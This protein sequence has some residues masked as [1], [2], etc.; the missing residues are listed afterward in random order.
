MKIKYLIISLA[1]LL[2]ASILNIIAYFAAFAITVMTGGVNVLEKDTALVDQGIFNV[3]R[4]LLIIIIFSW[5]LFRT[6]II[7]DMDNS[8]AISYLKKPVNIILIVLLGLFIQAGTDS[9][10]SLLSAAFPKAFASYK[11]LI[12]TFTGSSSA[13]FIITTFTLAPVAEELVFRGFIMG[14]L[15]KAVNTSFASHAS[16]TSDTNSETN[17]KWGPGVGAAIIIQALLFG[18]Y[19]GNIIQFIYASIFGI[20]LGLLTIRSKSLLPGIFLH[21][22]INASLYIMPERLFAK[23]YIT[24]PVFFISL[25]LIPFLV[26]KMIKRF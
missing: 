18:I 11:Y 3:L 23:V 9:A 25:F 4:Y 16:D 24:M 20:I 17:K 5:I 15:L 2:L 21:M 19:H 10:I 14:Y 1:G 13:L 8:L 26:R 22:I 6:D 7:S 12:E